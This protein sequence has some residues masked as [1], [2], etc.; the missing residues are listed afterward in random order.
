MI[1]LIIHEFKVQFPIATTHFIVNQKTSTNGQTKM[2]QGLPENTWEMLNKQYKNLPYS[3]AYISVVVICAHNLIQ[4][5]ARRSF[6]LLNLVA[7]LFD[8]LAICYTLLL[9]IDAFGW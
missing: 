5:S 6:Q 1:C 9:G 8:I 3:F 4:F 2:V 7:P